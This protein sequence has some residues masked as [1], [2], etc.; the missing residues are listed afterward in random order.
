MRNYRRFRAKKLGRESRPLL[1]ANPGRPVFPKRVSCSTPPT[2]PR[3]I[4]AMRSIPGAIEGSRD[5]VGFPGSQGACHLGRDFGRSPEDRFPDGS[6][7]GRGE[8][9]G[10]QWG[11]HDGSMTKGSNL[12][13]FMCEICAAICP[14]LPLAGGRGGGCSGFTEEAPVAQATI[15]RSPPQPSP[16]KAGEGGELRGGGD[17]AAGRR[18]RA[19]QETARRG[20]YAAMASAESSA[21]DDVTDPKMPPC[22][23]IIASPASWKCGKYEPQQSESTMQR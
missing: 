2:A 11:R 14:P 19:A 8:A 18:A 12:D 3:R 5:M 10:P 17:Y 13:H 9:R 15:R 23:L 20:N 1:A 21:C 16:A 7:G 22:A 6:D 4:A